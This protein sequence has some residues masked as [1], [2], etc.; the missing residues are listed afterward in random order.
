MLASDDIARERLDEQPQACRMRTLRCIARAPT[1][2]AAGTATPTAEP[3]E[4]VH[5]HAYGAID[6]MP[7]LRALFRPSS[8]LYVP[9]VLLSLGLGIQAARRLA[10]ERP[11]VPAGNQQEARTIN[12]GRCAD[13]REF[14][15]LI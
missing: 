9:A 6:P 4:R 7:L 3:S 1:P 8:R 10:A 14:H 2:G 12:L 15:H 13:I 11:S 5:D